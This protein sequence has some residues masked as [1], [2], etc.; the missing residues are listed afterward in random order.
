MG[1][2]S[3][4]DSPDLHRDLGL[5]DGDRGGE[6]GDEEEDAENDAFLVPSE[7]PGSGQHLR[8]RTLIRKPEHDHDPRYRTIENYVDRRRTY[9]AVAEIRRAELDPGRLFTE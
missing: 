2:A 3:T 6:E 9:L 7:S 5:G 4:V 1:I 8:P